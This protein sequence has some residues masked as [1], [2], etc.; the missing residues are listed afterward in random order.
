MNDYLIN[1]NKN[2]DLKPSTVSN[3]SEIDEITKHLDDHI[4]VCKIKQAYSKILQEDNFSFRM[5]SMDEVKRVVLTLN[6][7][8][9]STYGPIS[10]TILKQT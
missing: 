4:S 2:L 10:G 6:S 8:K 3:G 5:V 1:I 7:Q 9:S